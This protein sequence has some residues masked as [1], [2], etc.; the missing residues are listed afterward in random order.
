MSGTFGWY[1]PGTLLF[2][3]DADLAPGT[4]YTASVST[5]AKEFG[6]N[7]LTHPVAWSYRT[8]SSG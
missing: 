7:P 8:G 1:G 2:Q 5:A 3:T 4:Q 6:G